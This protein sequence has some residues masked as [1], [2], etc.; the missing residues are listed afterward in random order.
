MGLRLAPLE[1]GT[2]IVPISQR[3]KLRPG[4]SN[5]LCVLLLY[6]VS[7]W[8][9]PLDYELPVGGDACLFCL[10]MNPQCLE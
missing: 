7:D 5:I 10:F 8:P 6:V 9:T 3:R 1:V 4:D 2:V